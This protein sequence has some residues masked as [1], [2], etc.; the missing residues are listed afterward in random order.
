MP[1][2]ISSNGVVVECKATKRPC[3]LENY[4]TQSEATKVLEAEKIV[5]AVLANRQGVATFPP[6]SSNPSTVRQQAELYAKSD[7]WEA[8][9]ET[10]PEPEEE[11]EIHPDFGSFTQAYLEWKREER[12]K[13]EPTAAEDEQRDADWRKLSQ[14]YLESKGQKGA[15]RKSVVEKLQELVLQLF[16]KSDINEKN[17]TTKHKK[18]YVEGFNKAYIN[19]ET[20]HSYTRRNIKN[21]NPTELATEAY[22]MGQAR[23]SYA[24]K[25]KSEEVNFIK[26]PE[27]YKGPLT[28]PFTGRH[29]LRNPVKAGTKIIIPAGTPYTSTK[30]EK[31]QITQRATQIWVKTSNQGYI[32]GHNGR[33][34][35]MPPTITRA[36][37]SYHEGYAITPEILE[38][39]NMPVRETLDT[40]FVAMEKQDTIN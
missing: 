30:T 14:S 20:N 4:S 34:L 29:M 37:T 3:P 7:L 33:Q 23:A 36:G 27:S 19:G 17:K 22:L 6:N 39:N 8:S 11:E 18:A 10:T 35:A 25:L 28:Y 21:L 2:H 5:S 9:E 16:D 40:G 1:Y 13:E 32:T 31:E 24:V 12:E 38:A 15:P 26:E